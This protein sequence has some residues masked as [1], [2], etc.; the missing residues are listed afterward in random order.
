VI[1]AVKGA[2]SFEAVLKDAGI[3]LERGKAPCPFHEDKNPSFSVKGERGRCWAGCFNGDVIDF[4]A[5]YHGLDFQGAIK[6]L[7]DRAGIGRQ[8][9]AEARAAQGE[10]EKRAELVRTFRAWER[11]E[12]NRISGLLR[13]FRSMQARAR[14]EAELIALAEVH[15]EIDVLESRYE[16]LCG[17]DDR[18]KFELYREMTGRG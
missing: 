6:L 5:K 17:R 11:V 10:R 13:S 8:A 18:E 16:A 12:V 7:A 9:P 15:A 4:T 3:Y 1:E 2:W 14:T